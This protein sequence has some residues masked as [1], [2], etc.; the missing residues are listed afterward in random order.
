MSVTGFDGE[1][2]DE[3]KSWDLLNPEQAR[4]GAMVLWKIAQ[5]DGVDLREQAL[6]TALAGAT[7]VCLDVSTS[8]QW[9]PNI[10]TQH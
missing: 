10:S 9:C 7:V 3:L 8:R 1:Q 2:S 5:V 6:I 4:W